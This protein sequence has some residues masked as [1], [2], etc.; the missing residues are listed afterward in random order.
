ASIPEVIHGDQRPLFVA[1]NARQWPRGGLFEEKIDLFGGRGSLELE[2]A[3]GEG[4]VEQREAH[5]DAAQLAL[6]LGVDEPDS[7]GGSGARGNERQERRARAP[8]IFVRS[9]K[10]VLSI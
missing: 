4:C 1:E 2:H 10:E 9:I 8:G 7:G 5:G 6:Q 3:V